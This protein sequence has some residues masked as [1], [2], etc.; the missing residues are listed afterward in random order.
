MDA[1]LQGQ[2][3]AIVGILV[4]IRL[5][6]DQRAR[7][8]ARVQRQRG[9]AERESGEVRI[10]SCGLVEVAPGR[11]GVLVDSLELGPCEEE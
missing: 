5:R 3:I 1:R 4:E 7:R 8:I 9:A 11:G 10:E 2:G 6:I